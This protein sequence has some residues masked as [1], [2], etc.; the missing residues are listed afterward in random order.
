MRYILV[1]MAV[2]A[3]CASAWATPLS[4]TDQA[5]FATSTAQGCILVQ[6]KDP[7]NRTF[8]V[9]QMQDYCDCYGK[10]LAESVQTEELANGQQSLSQETLKKAGIASAKCGSVFKK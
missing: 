1:P 2:L 10:G 5:S 4:K 8:T 9:G 7:E 3:L 6:G